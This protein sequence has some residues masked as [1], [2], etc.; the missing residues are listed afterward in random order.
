MVTLPLYHQRDAGESFRTVVQLAVA[1]AEMLYLETVGLILL[2]IEC[3]EFIDGYLV[4]LVEV[5]PPFP[6]AS[7]VIIQERIGALLAQLRS[8]VECTHCKY[9][10]SVAGNGAESSRQRISKKQ[11]TD[12]KLRL[13]R[14]KKKRLTM[15]PASAT[16]NEQSYSPFRIASYFS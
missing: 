16:V 15:K 1:V 6:T 4:E 11:Q 9:I 7:E 2:I 12:D 3:V 14:T 5:R 8:H 13:Q 10:H